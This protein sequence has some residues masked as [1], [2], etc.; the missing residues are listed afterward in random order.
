MS[1]EKKGAKAL[2]RTPAQKRAAT[3][4]RKK[5]EREALTRAEAQRLA[6]IANLM[7]AGYSIPQIAD[8]LGAEPEE[9][10]TW[11]RRDMERYVRTQPALRQFVRNYISDRYTKLLD[12]VWDKAVDANHVDQ[13][14]SQDRAM[15]V[16][17]QMAKLHGAE[18]PAQHE[19]TLDAAPE[20]VEKMV[21]ALAAGKGLAYDASVFD[22]EDDVIDAEIVHEAAEQAG[23]A[24]EESSDRVGE[25]QEGDE[26]L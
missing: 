8:S 19:I 4:A 23:R 15:R 21:T 7:I 24:L 16:L 20:A 1:K 13:L 25:P 3:M 12:S 5:A 26:D 9:V 18:A 10:E 11:V 6:Q 14:A 22:D 2:D 17:N